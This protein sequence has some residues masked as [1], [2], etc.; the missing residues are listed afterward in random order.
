M[1][2]AESNFH[3][4]FLYPSDP[5]NKKVVDES[6]REEYLMAQKE[7]LHVHIFDTDTIPNSV[8][9]PSIDENTRIVYRGWMLTQARYAQLEQRFGAQLLTSAHDYCN[10]HY[11]PHWYADI[12]SL[13]ISSIIT[14]EIYAQE[15]FKHFGGKAFIKDYVKSLK[16]GTGSIVDSGADVMRAIADMK[17]Y[18]GA[19][20][21][22]IVLRVVV[23]FKPDSEI[24]FFIVKN[25]IFSPVV[26]GHDKYCLV[27][28]AVQ[29][30]AHKNMKFYSVDVA[31]TC[32]GR[33]IIIEIG[34]GQVS[35]YV[36][37]HLNDFIMVL[38][39]LGQHMDTFNFR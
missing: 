12:Q 39:Y 24:R 22:G 14:D 31:T 29:K 17:K 30:L 6:Y 13:T 28:E 36:G 8:V 15:Q 5:L 1:G 9:I 7:G 25:T 35:D 34:D 19:I 26:V 23:D 20:E 11:F 3:V 33:N 21:G 4:V 27:E 38:K 32:D 2:R 18:R 10:A 37:W 16:T